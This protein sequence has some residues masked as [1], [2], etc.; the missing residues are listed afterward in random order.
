MQLRTLT[1]YIK[2]P[3]SKHDSINFNLVSNLLSFCNL[4]ENTSIELS[5]LGEFWKLL[6]VD[7]V[8]DDYT[9]HHD[10]CN[11]KNYLDGLIGEKQLVEAELHITFSN[12]TKV[13]KGTP[14]PIIT[15][16]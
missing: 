4:P 5:K 9:N 8:E 2:A 16:E 6:V 1:I 13:T 14:S 10:T 3:C 12:A 15:E 7:N 11:I